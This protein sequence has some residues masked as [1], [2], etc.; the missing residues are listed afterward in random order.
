M[1]TPNAAKAKLLNDA[2][3]NHPTEGIR[4]M[5]LVGGDELRF[6]CKTMNLDRTMLQQLKDKSTPEVAAELDTIFSSKT[7]FVAPLGSTTTQVFPYLKHADPLSSKGTR[8]WAKLKDK[9]I[10][11]ERLGMN[12]VAV[13]A[14]DLTPC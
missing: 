6:Q 13:E 4:H 14:M 5:Y 10:Q 9:I 11:L 7:I 12:V 8:E 2:V 3:N 1:L